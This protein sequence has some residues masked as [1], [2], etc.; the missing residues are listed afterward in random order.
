MTDPE[1]L[2]SFSRAC[3]RI[4]ASL[5]PAEVLNAVAEAARSLTDARYVVVSTINDANRIDGWASAG[6][7]AEDQQRLSESPDGRRFLDSLLPCTGCEQATHSA[8]SAGTPAGSEFCQSLQISSCLSTPIEDED[9]SLGWI[10]VAQERVRRQFSRD[11]EESAAMLAAQAAMAITNARQHRLERRANADLLALIDTSPVGVVVF[12]AEAG[13]PV[14]VNQEGLRIARG[15]RMPG[16]SLPELTEVLICR[17]ADGREIAF[18]ELPFAQA[19]S[20]GET[21]RAEEMVLETPDGRSVTI[22]VNATP[23]RS[24][25]GAIESVVVT[26][27]D[28]TSLEA[29]ERLR[30]EFLGMVSHE[31]RMPLTSIKGSTTT[32]LNDI[33]ELDPAESR[34]FVEI[35]NEQ[36]DRMHGLINQLLDLARIEAGTLSV[37]PEPCEL[38]GLVDEARNLFL[39]SGGSQRIE[40]DLG[41]DLPKVRADRRRV[42]QVFSNLFANAAR[43]SESASKIR[44]TATTKDRRVLVSV[45]DDGRGVHPQQLPELFRR[46]SPL[47]REQDEDESQGSGL[48]LAISKGIVEAH[49]GR[50]WAESPAPEQGTRFTFTLPVAEEIK[51]SDAPP[52]PDTAASEGT[53]VLVVDDDPHALAFLRNT[54]TARGYSVIVTAD[55]D[56]AVRLV[57]ERQPAL[58]LLD[59]VF[60]GADGIELMARIFEIADLPVLFASA[61]GRDEIIAR[62]LDQGASDYLVKPFSPT[63][64][65]ARVRAALRQSQALDSI[66]QRAPYR[67][68]DLL[69]DYGARRVTQAGRAV[70][71]APTEYQL[72]VELSL[73]AG[74][75]VTHELLLRR[76][77]GLSDVSDARFVRAAVKRLR[78]KLGDDANTPRYIATE[79]RVGY[80]LAQGTESATAVAR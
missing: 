44:V 13:L 37:D 35:I 74:R 55:P 75:V 58:V 38:V 65:I 43:Y 80:R 48:G 22:L 46:F 6:F 70:Q 41:L 23:I 1:R 66:E 7:S 17:R 31:L 18:N 27:Q 59:L 49:G 63:E 15:L 20:T 8:Q 62:A 16:R 24:E 54:L 3:L 79:P 67:C 45:S 9:Q 4:H 40:V 11:G 53:P 71:L 47:D 12:D 76:V 73:H 25:A 21:V 77:W 50:I 26:L 10:W 64:L 14:S 60:P 57:R 36:A 33:T 51:A 30:A 56:D 78:R 72:L 69:I 68:G 5:D 42:V 52:I 34:R 61:Y 2:A 39:N 28:L 29:V 32:L 19:L